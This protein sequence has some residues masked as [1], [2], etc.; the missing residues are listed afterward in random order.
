MG[1]FLDAN[2]DVLSSGHVPHTYEELLQ[3]LFDDMASELKKYL[4]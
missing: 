4:N 1:P 2:H 3:K